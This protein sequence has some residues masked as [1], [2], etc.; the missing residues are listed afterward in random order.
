MIGLNFRLQWYNFRRRSSIKNV[1]NVPF[2]AP[3]FWYLEFLVMNGPIFRDFVPFR[4]L[5]GILYGSHWWVLIYFNM[6]FQQHIKNILQKDIK[7]IFYLH[8][9]YILLLIYI[10]AYIKHITI[11]FYSYVNYITICWIYKCYLSVIRLSYLAKLEVSVKG[12]CVH[13]TDEQI[14]LSKHFH[15]LR[16]G[17]TFRSRSNCSPYLW[18]V[19]VK[20]IEY[21]KS[22]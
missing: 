19:N 6:Y 18:I 9:G 7:I 5:T 22:F 17:I 21:W 2:K 15:F 12:T 16:I 13:C 1:P 8:V 14:I 3:K 10:L 4:I 11:I 20:N